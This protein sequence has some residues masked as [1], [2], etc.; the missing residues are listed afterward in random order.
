VPTGTEFRVPY[1]PPG[2]LRVELPTGE[3]VT[4]QHTGGPWEFTET[5]WAGAY[6]VTSAG[7]RWAFHATLSDEQESNLLAPAS[8]VPEGLWATASAA[9][10]SQT[11]PP[12]PIERWLLW[13]AL[14][15]FVAEWFLYQRRV[16]MRSA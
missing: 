10:A 4:T 7:N 13:F 3:R 6:R 8:R 14:G 12:R 2:E 1:L 16:T 15:C 11:V 9:S 5:W